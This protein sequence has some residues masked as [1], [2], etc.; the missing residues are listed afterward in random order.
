MILKSLKLILLSFF[1]LVT[2]VNAKELEK[3]SLQLQWL[4][5]FQFAGYYIAKEKG[6]YKDVNL[7]VEIKSYSIG[8]NIVTK[9]VNNEVQYATGRNYLIVERSKGKKIHL[10][11]AIF[12]TSPLVMVAK[13][14]SGIEKIE[15]F[16]DKK[17][18][19]GGVDEFESIF[20]MTVSRHIHMH[21]MKEVKT[22]TGNKLQHLLNDNVDVISAYTS[23]E[24]HTLEEKG[25]DVNIFNPKDYGFDF[26]GDILFTNEHEITDHKQRA[27][28]FKNASLK[29]WE[30]AFNN[31]DE[32]V[33]IILEKYNTQNKSK[34]ALVHEAK[35]L[36]KLAYDKAKKLGNIDRYKIQRIYDIYNI[37]GFV[38]NVIDVDEFI[39]DNEKEKEISFTQEEMQYLDKNKSISFTGDPNWLPFEAFDSYGNYIG[40]VADHLEYIENSINIK[41]DK[42]VSKSWANAISMANAGEADIISGDANDKILNQKFKP[43]DTYIIN[44]IMIITR[45]KDGYI[46]NLNEIKD[47]KIAIIK[48]Y[49]YT[50]D[51]FKRYPDIDF[52]E[53]DNIQDGLLGIENKKYDAMLASLALASYTIAHMNLDSVSIVGKTDIVM[54]VT[55]FVTKEKPLLHSIINKAMRSISSIEQQN[56]LLKW[57][58]TKEKTILV[59]YTLAW[60]I[61]GASIII[62]LFFLYRQVIL[63]KYNKKL[64]DEVEKATAELQE[65]NKNFEYLLNTTMEAIILSDENN[66]I[67]DS[68]ESGLNLF[69]VKGKSALIGR[70]IREFVADHELLKL[71][72]ALAKE[73]E[74]PRPYDLINNEGEVFPTLASGRDIIMEGKKV[75]VSIILDLTQIKK[76][77]QQLFAQSRLAQMGEMISMIAHQWRQPLGAISATVLNLEVEIALEEFDLK[78]KED[79]E[80]YHKHVLERLENINGFVNDL[81]VTID[82]FRNFYKPNK[83]SKLILLDEIVLKALGIIKVSLQGNKIE[84]LEH[85]NTSNKLEVFDSEIMQ[86]VLNIL[87][88]SQDNFR[89]KNVKNSKIIIEVTDRSISICDNGG[90][91]EENVIEKIFDPYFST[92]DEK[93]GS[94][95]GLYMSKIIIEEH[96][97]GKL[98]VSNRD[99]GACFKIEL[100]S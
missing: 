82:D 70:N 50:A 63:N 67:I 24:I 78:T 41:F 89:E 44:P 60:Q 94:G 68:N 47:K 38:K 97:K 74:A 4:D 46:E 85:Y 5:Q 75:R 6:F 19:H 56:I 39:F 10:L 26:Y 8:D 17:I 33:E 13:K 62:I 30:Y 31:I 79:V 49:G 81:T 21:D 36:K 14:S 42:K 87:K 69:K 83:K 88:N 37:M 22:K 58:Y 61:F 64:E 76:Q 99:G 3:V 40:I 86:V 28:N 23:N 1:L 32:T 15:D 98:L 27:I 12:Q 51:V 100:D 96:H 91:I 35:E 45:H 48:D 16:K 84:I 95:L 80:K 93:N 34:E 20:A 18:M 43:I 55:L 72:E 25:V 71:K 7:E 92:K 77:E 54:N 73:Y 59:D 11:S 90:G 2:L 65:K 53:V 57:R 52:I 9:V 29:G 66:I